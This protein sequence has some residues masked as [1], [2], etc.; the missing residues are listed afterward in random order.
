MSGFKKC[1]G[2]E[3]F[4]C[5]HQPGSYGMAMEAPLDERGGN[6]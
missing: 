1:S 5:P 2:P 6:R 4:K 3:V